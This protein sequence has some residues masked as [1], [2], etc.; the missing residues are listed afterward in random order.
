VLGF[1]NES[2]DIVWPRKD[3]LSIQISRKQSLL[4]FTSRTGAFE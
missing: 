3:R 2:S 1:Q 4:A